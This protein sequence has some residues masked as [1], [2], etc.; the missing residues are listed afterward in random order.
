MAT[1]QI[2]KLLQTVVNQKASDLHIT[3]GQPPVLRMGGRMVRLDTK[4]LE[5]DDCMSLMKSVTPERNQQELQEVGGT[6]FGFAFGKLARFRV[7]VFKQRGNIGMVLRRIPNEF[8]T[9]EQLG[10]PPI[11]RDLI[12]RPRG[13]F[14]VTGPT[15]SGKTTSLASM[16][17]YLNDTVDHH[18]ITM[19]DPIEYYHEHKK[20]TINQREIGVDVPDF[21]EAL[22][23]ALRMDPDVMLVGE[24]RDLDTIQ[25]AITAAE[26]GHVVFGTLH[27]TGAEGT[28]NRIIDVFP[29]S[30]QEQIRTQLSVA[31]IG[32]LSQALLPR[33]P[34]G[35]VAAYEMLVVTPA[36][37]NLIR[38]NKTYRVPS[39]IQTG[40]KY[41]MQLL[42]DNLFDLWKKG[43]VEE[44]DVVNRS[45]QPG[46]IKAKIAMAKKG[47][48]SEDE[49]EDEFDFE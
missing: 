19:E 14:L 28:I 29:T 33:K 34:K 17:N 22:R 5:A 20:S 23:R 42:D 10:L 38:E 45:N 2:D 46:E 32:I 44:H 37:A 21:P 40:K 48:L 13:L 35:L 25:A 12:M 3:V 24:M 27:T 1:I 43:M 31:I 30:Q 6:D 39:S 49:E 7:A 4:V 47:L 15:G 11:V 26:T 8:L 18:I 9:F 41:G 16:I 36:I